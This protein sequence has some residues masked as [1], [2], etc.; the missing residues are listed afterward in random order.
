M[1]FKG[2]ITDG[3]ISGTLL[4]TV[5]RKKGHP[6][7]LFYAVFGYLVAA[8]FSLRPGIAYNAQFVNCSATKL[9]ISD[10]I[11]KI[12]PAIESR[13]YGLLQGGKHFPRRGLSPPLALC[14]FR[15]TSAE[16][17]WPAL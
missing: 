2:H 15:R 8:D 11:C 12:E 3:F 13:S 10:S 14:T 6:W 4:T 16:P 17:L 7:F 5:R 9:E 1:N